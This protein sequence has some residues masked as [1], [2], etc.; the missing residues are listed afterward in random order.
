MN[1]MFVVKTDKGKFILRI[2]KNTKTKKDLSFEINLL[3]ALQGMPVPRYIKD[4]TGKYINRFQGHHYSIY[5]YLEGKIPT[6]ITPALVNE[7]ASFLAKFHNQTK[8]FNIAQQRFAWY[9][10]T[11][12]R[13][14]E[15][16]KYMNG[17]LADYKEEIQYLKSMLLNNQLPETI[18]KGP[19]HVDVR[20]EN[21]LVIGNSLTGVV[22]FDNCQIG[23]YILDLAMSIIWICTGKKGL[24]YKKAQWFLQK[25]EMFR[26]LSKIEKRYLF[27]AITYAYAA[28]V[29]V[30]HYV[31]AKGL[32]TEEHFHFGRTHFLSALRK[33]SCEKFCI[34]SPYFSLIP[35][36][37]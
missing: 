37:Q 2:A 23:P 16:E 4:S 9:N 30:N 28:Q 20:R 5:R 22:D 10:F 31:Y 18:P 19:I 13:A 7:I 25:Y 27:Q 34:R 3:N 6:E 17:K 14:D 21:L 15:F 35:T 33:L 12:R 11:K 1:Y 26:K 36:G 32:V 8:N 24:D 29:F